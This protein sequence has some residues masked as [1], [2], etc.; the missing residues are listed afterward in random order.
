MNELCQ[1]YLILGLRRCL[2]SLVH[3]CS[4]CRML[5]GLL[6]E[7][8]MGR[9]PLERLGYG[10]R[11]FT[12]SGLDLFGPIFVKVG[13]RREKRWGVLFSCLTTRAIW[14]EVAHSLTADSTILAIERFAARRGWP[15]IL[16]SDNGTNFRRAS[17][18]LRQALR[19]LDREKLGRFALD[20][21]MSCK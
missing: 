11:P 3:K 14:L 19:L 12:S 10:L 13:R 8:K 17:E 1:E 5:R 4:F 21:G 20:R 15:R 16:W 7:P 6:T 18:E 2:R 9:L